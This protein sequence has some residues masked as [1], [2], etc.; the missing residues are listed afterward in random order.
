MAKT[1][2]DLVSSLSLP[3]QGREEIRKD[4]AELAKDIK[5]F[6]P[7]P[8]PIVGIS[9]L[10]DGFIEGY[11]YD[12]S[13]HPEIDGSKPLSLLGHVGGNPILAVV[14]RS[15]VS[16]AH[17]D[18]LSKWAVIGYRYFDKYA[19][20]KMSADERKK[21][22]KIIAQSRP[23]LRR[24]DETNRRMLLPA[25]ADGQI[26]FVVDTKLTSKRFIETLPP[27][28]KPMP[29]IE[30][31]LL[32]GVSDAALLEKAFREYWAIGNALVDVVRGIEGATIPAD[33]KIPSAKA[34][35]TSQGTIYAYALPKPW[36]VDPKVLPNA[37]LARDVVAISLSREHT[38]RLLSVT[39][40]KV[41]GRALP[42]DRPLGRCLR[43]GFRRA[44]RFGDSL[45][46]PGH[47]QSRPESGRRTD[48]R[49]VDP[50]ASPYSPGCAQGLP[51]FC[52]RELPGGQDPGDALPNGNPR[53]RL[54]GRTRCAP[55]GG[56]G[57]PGL[58]D[59]TAS[60]LSGW[61]ESEPERPMHARGAFAV[62]SPAQDGP[63][64]DSS[65]GPYCRLPCLSRIS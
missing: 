35:T 3:S 45:G 22:D 16:V 47:R 13:E 2:G 12:W 34:I 27:T 38:Q 14:N 57:N 29:M 10:S 5:P 64:A 31:A 23:L 52:R 24:F 17:Y 48:Q 9:F 26:G 30:P 59:G 15:K 60:R 6:I 46:G 7:E 37:G 43:A 44:D 33:F 39:P 56:I 11:A 20:A 51:G 28:E 1:V 19:G 50:Q 32:L 55:R 53:R 63:Q 49:R 41:G 54:T 42:T 8:G 62:V 65:A 40:P 4:I 61:T 18:L 21:Y 36:G 58:F 25:L